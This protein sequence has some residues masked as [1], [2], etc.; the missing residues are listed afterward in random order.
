L[1][2][3]GGR[4]DASATSGITWNGTLAPG[5]DGTRP[6]ELRVAAKHFRIAALQPLFVGSLS[7]IDGL[8]DGHVDV[9]KRASDVP[10]QIDAD[11]KV[12]SGV[13]NVPQLGQEFRNARV[14]LQSH[15]NEL[16]LNDLAA[17]GIRGKLHGS[18]VIH[19]DDLAFKD[20]TFEV[21]IDH[22]D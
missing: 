13:V 11:M 15:D 18:G 2:Q 8:L 22:G 21:V 14:A 20:A 19:V 3:D 1:A 5:F 12:S 4:L 9:L 6:G 16:R 17:D 7:R 10:A